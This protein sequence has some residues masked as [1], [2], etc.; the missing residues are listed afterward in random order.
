MQGYQVDRG[1]HASTQGIRECACAFKS[2]ECRVCAFTS[3][4]LSLPPEEEEGDLAVYA[5]VLC[6]S[7]MYVLLKAAPCL[8]QSV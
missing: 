1:V 4:L 3:E 7:Y 8:W 2:R 6:R 5:Y